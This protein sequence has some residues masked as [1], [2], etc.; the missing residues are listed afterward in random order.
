MP[1]WSGRRPPHG[2]R[3]ALGVVALDPAVPR[4]G[5]YSATQAPHHLMAKTWLFV[6]I[7]RTATLSIG[8][9]PSHVALS[10][11]TAA[12]RAS[13]TTRLVIPPC[14]GAGDGEWIAFPGGFA[15]DRPACVPLR[16]VADDRSTT[17][18]VSLGGERCHE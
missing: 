17:I 9:G 15:F 18:H 12:Q 1:V 11:G 8:H 10:W 5:T 3:S 6:R 13:W 4:T 7:H 14:P 2:T 16:L